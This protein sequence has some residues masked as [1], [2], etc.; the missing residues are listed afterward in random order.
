MIE[1][2][3]T[4]NWRLFVATRR[5]LALTIAFSAATLAILFLAIYPQIGTLTATQR[6]LKS[7]QAV[8]EKLRRKSIELEQIK[9]LPEFA[10]AD[11]VNEVLPSHKPV[12]E[13]LTSLNNAAVTSQVVISDF[14][15]SPGE[16]ATDSTKAQIKTKKSS[17]NFD[18]LKLD[19]SVS[20]PL[21]NVEKFMTLI[22]RISP[23][24]TITNLSLS[25]RIAGSEEAE[26]VEAKADLSLSTYFFTQS[27][28]AAIESPLP[29]IGTKEQNIFQTVQEFLPSNLESQTEVQGGGQTDFFGIEKL[30]LE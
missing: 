3:R 4:F 21:G 13:L 20:G 18:V 27:I 16:I 10:Q 17:G 14:T 29:Q 1:K 23:I 25:R 6:K 9:T 28:K 15:I 8:V 12:L 2:K 19:L 24:T 11:V 5:Y 22:E 26:E 7:E 30:E